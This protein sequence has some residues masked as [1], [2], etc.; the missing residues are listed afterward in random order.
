[1]LHNRDLKETCAG[2]SES[3]VTF[4]KAAQAAVKLMWAN[5]EQVTGPQ[6]NMRPRERNTVWVGREAIGSHEK[7]PKGIVKKLT[8]LPEQPVQIC[9]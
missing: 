9:L 8:S 5:L 2:A 3:E 7:N 6:E 1:M 4:T